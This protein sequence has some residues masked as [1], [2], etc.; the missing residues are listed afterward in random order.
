MNLVEEFQL[1]DYIKETVNMCWAHDVVL[2]ELC[3]CYNGIHEGSLDYSTPL[4]HSLNLLSSLLST[5]TVS[6]ACTWAAHT[7]STHTCPML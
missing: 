5:Y 7:H 1:G 4:N 6:A 3:T 2:C